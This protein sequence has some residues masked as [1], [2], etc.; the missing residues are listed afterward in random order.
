MARW[1]FKEFCGPEDWSYSEW[2]WEL[3]LDDGQI[4]RRSPTGF[5][6]LKHCK[7]DAT[8]HGYYGGH[9]AVYIEQ[10]SRTELLSVVSENG[11]AS[12]MP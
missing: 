1:V 6:D 12:G 3:V 7:A 2:I 4:F 8:K 5:V 11:P 10:P 9:Y